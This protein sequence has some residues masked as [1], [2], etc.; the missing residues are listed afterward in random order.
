MTLL[1]FVYGLAFFTL[2]ATTIAALAL[3]PSS[4]LAISRGMGFLGLFGLLHGATEWIVMAARIHESVASWEVVPLGLSYVALGIYSAYPL[5]R[6]HGKVPV[7]LA[8]T[9]ALAVVL[10]SLTRRS[11][12]VTE[13]AIRYVIGLPSCLLVARRLARERHE[14]PSH[15]AVSRILL[16]LAWVFV[17]YGIVACMIVPRVSIFPATVLNQQLF[18]A[19]LGFPI[20]IARAATAIVMTGCVLLALRV[21]KDEVIQ[22]LTDAREQLLA[23]IEIRTRS[24]E[25]YR[26]LFNFCPLPA[27][28]IDVETLRLLAVNDAAVRHYGY[29]ADE[30]LELRATELMAPEAAG[31][32]AG[33]LARAPADRSAHLGVMKHRR[34][35]GALI[36]VDTVVHR[37]TFDGR[38]AVLGI[39]NDV[40]EARKLEEQLRQA[41]KL[42]AIGRLAGGV[43]HDFS[44]I[45]A[46]IMANADLAIRMWGQDHPAAERV[47]IIKRTAKRGAA[48]TRQLLAFSRKDPPR[49]KLLALSEI[50]TSVHEMLSQVVGSHIEMAT[51]LAPQLGVVEA[52][53]IQIEQ[54]IMNLVLNAR[55]AMPKG[56]RLVIEAANEDLDAARAQALGIPHGP[57]VRLGVR[58][59]GSGMDAA[60]RARIFEPFFTTKEAGKGTGLGL[61]TALKIVQ[62]NSGAIAVESE[63]GRGTT[64]HVY[65]PRIEPAAA[66]IPTKGTPPANG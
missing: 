10:A 34:K 32:L 52:D 20:Q 49:P 57:Y 39:G 46:V 15:S 4:R 22:G 26:A 7:A 47:G 65:L 6:A 27:G 53:E 30:L 16:I 42:D 63:I 1:L 60:V 2:G 44:N 40:T 54:V 62:E 66:A 41:Q 13:V 50:V 19:W 11:E 31:A 3:Q 55:D 58:D 14:L 36:D 12:P 21:F 8:A 37:I 43:A 33:A 18:R 35:D 64:F 28:V 59:T 17:A 29:S 5:V 61:S 9:L 51:S 23:Q 45:L 56:G 25:R 38:T 24:E 48:L